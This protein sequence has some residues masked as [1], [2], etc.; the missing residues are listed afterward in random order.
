MYIKSSLDI[1]G[2]LNHHVN[3]LSTPFRLL[4]FFFSY[5][6]NIMTVKIKLFLILYLFF[7]FANAKYGSTLFKHN[8]P[9]D[10]YR[11]DN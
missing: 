3:D 11:I 9:F 6:V 4:F 5:F 2:S 7:H 1:F 8:V 10:G